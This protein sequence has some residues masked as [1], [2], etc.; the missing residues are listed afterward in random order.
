MGLYSHQHERRRAVLA[1]EALDEESVR[2]RLNARV[3]R[4]HRRGLMAGPSAIDR[5]GHAQLDD[6]GAGEGSFSRIANEVSGSG[7]PAVDDGMK[8][9]G[10]RAQIL[11]ACAIRLIVGISRSQCLPQRVR[12][13]E[14]VL[15]G[16]R[17]EIRTTMILSFAIPGATRAAMRDRVRGFKRG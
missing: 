4:P 6:V 16:R 8:A 14:D 13:G 12:D 2:L 3:Q 10:R 9:R 7:S 11:K 17:P 1:P 15:V 5:E